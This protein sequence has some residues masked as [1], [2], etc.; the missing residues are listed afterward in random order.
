MTDSTPD[1][2]FVIRKEPG[3]PAPWAVHLP[4]KHIWRNGVP[5]EAT[6]TSPGPVFT[7]LRFWT[8]QEAMDWINNK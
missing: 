6:A 5:I 3:R 1:P 8:W 7:V 2:W 4:A